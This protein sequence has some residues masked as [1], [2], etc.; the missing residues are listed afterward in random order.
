MVINHLSGGSCGVGNIGSLCINILLSNIYINIFD[1]NLG[2]SLRLSLLVLN[3]N[4]VLNLLI[5]HIGNSGIHFGTTGFSNSCINSVDHFILL[6]DISCTC[7]ND[8]SGFSWI[9]NFSINNTIINDLRGGNFSCTTNIGLSICG[10]VSGCTGTINIVDNSDWNIC[11]NCGCLF[12]NY[13]DW[14]SSS[15]DSGSISLL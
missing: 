7:V 3:I 6:I 1:V 11:G 4:I 2:W 5:S 15:D 13:G 10:S 14:S 12:S 8:S 9:V